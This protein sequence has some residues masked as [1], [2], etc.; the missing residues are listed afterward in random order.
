MSTVIV[1]GGA[2]VVLALV[3]AVVLRLR[4]P[5]PRFVS[6]A[7]PAEPVAAVARGTLLAKIDSTFRDGRFCVLLGRG[8]AGKTH[9]AA[10]YVRAGRSPV[11]WVPAEDP[12][13]AFAALASGPDAEAAAREG[14]A[15]LDG[16]EDALVVFDGATDPDALNRWLPA[17]ARVLVTTT[18]PDFEVLGP[19]LPVPAFDEPEAVGFLRARSGR[20]AAPAEVARELGGLPLALAQAGG[21]IRTS[22]FGEYLDRLPHTPPLERDPGEDHS[23]CVED[24]TIAALR[25]V[26]ARDGRA[27][28]VAE[29]LAVLGSPGVR[30]ALVHRVGPDPVA[31]DAALAGLASASLTE[32]DTSGEV[33][34]MHRLTRRAILGRLHAEDR[35]AAALDRAF[36]VVAAEETADLTGHAAALWRH[37]RALPSAESG[38]RLGTVLRLRRR[39]VDLLTAEGA[40]GQARA[41][42]REVLA[43]HEAYL[44]RGHEDT[45]RA[46][47]ALGRANEDRTGTGRHRR[48]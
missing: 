34:T 45:A 31:V 5:R 18:V 39:S 30:R 24:T 7:V 14:L 43:D 15:W 44:P 28:V 11:V 21:V 48:A 17:R 2:I 3:T 46:A 9:L 23:P 19:T 42:G 22:G 25:A 20:D 8:G 1:A 40:H 6:G 41:L 36:A 35:M 26:A 32:F 4:R 16:L 38:P 27:S 37:F 10:A 12:A 33:V 13:R 29:L 47:R